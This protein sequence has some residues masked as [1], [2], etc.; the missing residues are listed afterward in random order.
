[1]KSY[2][3]RERVLTDDVIHISEKGK[4]FKGGYI[5]ILEH[6]QFQN[7]WSDR[8]CVKRF[9]SKNAIF[10]YLKK[11]YTQEEYECLEL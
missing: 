7:A 8:K 10:D 2:I 3:L 9:K 5:A 11:N 4:I 6:H 1:M